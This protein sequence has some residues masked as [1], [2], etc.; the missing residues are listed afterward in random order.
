MWIYVFNMYWLLFINSQNDCLRCEL[1][2]TEE[3]RNMIICGKNI[4]DK[5]TLGIINSLTIVYEEEFINTDTY[6]LLECEMKLLDVMNYYISMRD[7]VYVVCEKRDMKYI[8]KMCKLSNRING[9][10]D[11]V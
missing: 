7:V 11:K 4:Y 9:F 8:N 2:Y 5:E 6:K 3:S 1:M 10:L